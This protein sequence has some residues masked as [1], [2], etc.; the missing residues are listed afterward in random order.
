MSDSEIRAKYLGSRS[1]SV[2]C[3]IVEE[4]VRAV[5]FV[6]YHL[7]DDGR[8]GG[9]MDLVLSP[10]ERGR[11][12]GTAVVEAL[13]RFVERHLG[14]ERLTVDPDLS[15]PRG[16]HFWRTVGFTPVRVVTDDAEREPYVLMERSPSHE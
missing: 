1:P 5:G 13:V 2:E 8:Q 9:G 15:N 10:S 14:W 16:V 11:G 4:G 6:Q 12:L 7:A 3:F